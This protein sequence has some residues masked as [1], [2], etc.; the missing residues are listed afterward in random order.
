MATE[1]A[2]YEKNPKTKKWVISQAWKDWQ[3]DKLYREEKPKANPNKVTKKNHFYRWKEVALHLDTGRA[4][5]FCCCM[6]ATNEQYR[7]CGATAIRTSRA[8]KII[9]VIQPRFQ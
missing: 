3:K 6:S 5:F 7:S 2:K 8:S 1:P 9:E 4:I